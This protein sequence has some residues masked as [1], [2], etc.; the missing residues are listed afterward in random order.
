[1]NWFR[2]LSAQ[3]TSARPNST[4]TTAGE[5]LRIQREKA[6]VMWNAIDMVDNSGLCSGIL[7]KFPTYICGTLRWQART[8]D[9]NVNVA[10]QQYIQQKTSKPGNID[11]TGRNSLRL[12]CMLDI[13]SIMLKGDVGTNI[14]RDTDD[15]LYLQGIEAN[16]IGDP[17]RWQTSDTYVRGLSLDPGTGRI[18]SVKVFYQDRRSGTYKFDQEFQMRDKHGLPKFLFFTNPISYDDYRGVSLF[19]SCIDSDTYIT[20]M[21][22]YELQALLWASSQSGVYYTKSGALPEALPFS[23]S[24]IV[25]KDGNTIE[26]FQTHPNTLVA[27]SADGEK[28]EMFQHDRPSPNVIGMYENTIIDIC[29]GLGVTKQFGWGMSGTGPEVRMASAQDA[30]AVEMWQQM[31]REMKLDDVIMLLLGDAITKGELPYH[32]NWL[33]WDW[34]FPA[35]PTIDVG[36][37]SEANI[38]EI[39]AG[40]NTGANVVSESGQGDVEDVITQRSHEIGMMIDAAQEIA[41]E[42]NLPWEQVYALMIPPPRGRGQGGGMPAAAGIAADKVAAQNGDK[43]GASDDG[44]EIDGGNGNGNG[45]SKSSSRFRMNEDG[46][47]T[48]FYRPDQARGAAGTPEGGQFIPEGGGNNGGG[49]AV[50]T[51]KKTE[52]ITSSNIESVRGKVDSSKLTK[53]ADKIDGAFTTDA[54]TRVVHVNSLVSP[55]NEL[56]DPKF[57]AGKKSDPRQTATDRMVEAIERGG[58]KRDPLKVEDNGDGTYTIKDGNAT[59]QAAMLA[60]WNHLP[61]HVEAKA[62]ELPYAEP[63]MSPLDKKLVDYK[64]GERPLNDPSKLTYLDKILPNTRFVPYSKTKFFNAVSAMQGSDPEKV[65]GGEYKQARDDLMNK[66][67]VAEIPLDKLVVTQ[68]GV[69]KD[70]M[71]SIEKWPKGMGPKGTPLDPIQVVRYNGETY[72]LNGHHRAAAF[73]NRGDE[74]TKAHVLTLTDDEINAYE[75]A[76]KAKPQLDAMV[77]EVAAAHNAEAVTPPLKSIQRTRAKVQGDYGGD[78]SRIKDIA[79]AR[80]L[81]DSD[82][83]SEAVKADLEKR[84][85]MEPKLPPPQAQSVGFKDYKFNPVIGGQ[86]VEISV[87]TDH[88]NT[89][90]NVT[91][92][93]YEKRQDIERNAANEKRALT[94]SELAEITALDNQ[95]SFIFNNGNRGLTAN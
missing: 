90:T 60:G 71:A 29:V 15:E 70:R 36:R 25:D 46:S 75:A 68:R 38:E 37:E 77:K 59:A 34:Y 7:T 20:N 83:D 43:P 5:W 41:K 79:R 48:V 39:N 42:R 65:T 27:L 82:A 58:A 33:T 26:T 91:H 72:I 81:S 93:V 53:H 87:M 2:Y 94:A 32:P 64:P 12:Q 62:P 51:Q 16:R 67:P 57:V 10:Y 45:N 11:I 76:G 55:K 19:K 56:T 74:T 40:L 49:T 80:I 89:M 17:Y 66:Q 21:R 4:S 22:K 18:K 3:P 47:I 44:V 24:P 30:R 61:V 23:R 6:Q 73:K 8:G 31:L 14:I 50:A 86:K 84:L 92:G 78:W 88:M 69:N 13:K 54:N 28:V 52:K 9:K 95:M 1:M 85:G 63:E 35:K